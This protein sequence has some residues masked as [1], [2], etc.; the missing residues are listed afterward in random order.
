MAKKKKGRLT[1]IAGPMFSGKTTKA[2]T[3]FRVLTRLGYPV[4]CFKAEVAGTGG[5]GHTNSHDERTL[6]VIFIDPSHPERILKY[7]F[8]DKMK[9]IID[10]INFFPKNKAKKLISELLNQGVDVCATGLIY[11]Y[12]KKPFGATLDLFKKADEKIELF[13]ICVKCG[14]RADQTERVSGRTGKVVSTQEAE[15]VPVCASCHKVYR[16]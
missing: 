1:V 5:L 2:L 6:P 11:D 12:T 13:A 4:L 15:Y 16:G 3:L 8:T 14:G 7:V 9:V 10:N